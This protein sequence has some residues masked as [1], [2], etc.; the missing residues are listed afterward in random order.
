MPLTSG[1]GIA[2]VSVLPITS[3][4]TPRRTVLPPASFTLTRSRADAPA[5]YGGGADGYVVRPARERRPDRH[6]GQPAV[7]DDQGYTN[8]PHPSGLGRVPVT[9]EVEHRRASGGRAEYPLSAHR[10]GPGGVL[11]QDR[12]QLGHMKLVQGM[13]VV[14]HRL[15]EVGGHENT[16]ST[17]LPWMWPCAARVCALPAS[18]SG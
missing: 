5:G 8:T 9:D 11:G 3:S 7:G 10:E 1:M 17:I 14:R 12:F 16:V 13:D 15:L 6:R 4:P 18:E 2:E